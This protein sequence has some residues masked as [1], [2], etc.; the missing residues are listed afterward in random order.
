MKISLLPGVAAICLG[1][2]SALGA[3]EA[4]APL[5]Y[6]WLFV[7]TAP[8][9][10]VQ[11]PPVYP[12]REVP[13]GTSGQATV[14]FVVNAQGEIKEA[15][16]VVPETTDQAFSRVAAEAVL[17]WKYRP[18]LKDGR[19]VR[20]RLQAPFVFDGNGQVRFL[21]RPEAY[22][23]YTGELGRGKE[24]QPAR[25]VFQARPDFP[26]KLR[27]QGMGG[28]VILR[29]VITAEGNVRNVRLVN[30]TYPE[31]AVAAANSLMRWKF[32]P[33]MLQGR[34]V[35]SAAMVPFKF[36]VRVGEASGIRK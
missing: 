36:D 12:A 3:Q 2:A 17:K 1:A 9:P 31:L 33:A 34:P 35:A 19:P 10:V 4:A 6:D 16:L 28:E 14:E 7:D 25:P 11:E 5:T 30:S 8:A 24:L 22:S 29:L 15:D 21:L 20:T 26:P 27:D 18:G 23:P 32:Q 13:P